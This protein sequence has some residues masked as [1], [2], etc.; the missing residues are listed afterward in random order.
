MRANPGAYQRR[1]VVAGDEHDLAVGAEAHADRA[2]DRVR[3]S[4]A[5]A[6]GA[7]LHQLDDVAEQHEAVDVVERASSRSQRLGATEDVVFEPAAE[8]EIRDDEGPHAPPRY[9][10]RR[11]DQRRGAA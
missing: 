6:G 11:R 8:V 5:R 9:P 10:R 2:Q 7:T 3:R 4:A 1:V